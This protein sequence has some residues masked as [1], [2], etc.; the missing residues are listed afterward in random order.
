MS[1]LHRF[2]SRLRTERGSAWKHQVDRWLGIP[3]LGVCSVWRKFGRTAK[4]DAPQEIG[5]LCLG[6]IGDMLL[7]TCVFTTLHARWPHARITLFTS[8][9]NVRAA[10]LVPFV[11]ENKTFEVTDIV[12]LLRQVRSAHFDLFVDTGQWARLGALVCALSGAGQTVGFQTPGQC[13][14]LAFERT[15]AHR[16]DQHELKNFQA[17][18]QAA[19]GCSGAESPLLCAPEPALHGAIAA[20]AKGHPLVA[21][22]P[23]PSG[24]H[25]HLKE[26]PE[27]NWIA[28]AEN[29]TAR[30]FRVLF[31]GSPTDAERI[32]PLLDRLSIAAREQTLCIA[33]MFSFRDEV[34]L[35]Q[36]LDAFISVN[37]GT[38]HLSAML[39]T[40]TVDMHG[41][42][43]P[44]RWG[45]LGAKVIHMQPLSGH[46]A[47]LHLG[48]EY[49]PNAENVLRHLP[50]ASV[51]DALRQFGGPFVGPCGDLPNSTA[52]CTEENP[53]R[54][55]A[56]EIKTLNLCRVIS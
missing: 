19:A 33:G 30:G 22:H 49:P 28:L 43:N 45:G 5:V 38:M 8:R 42:T 47:Y 1:D 24:I 12:G 2:T 44:L 32:A 20:F 17:L 34:A 54:Q 40:P 29:L 35:L 26:W 14:H 3:L 15:A 50:L 56:L 16:N 46:C 36:K 39:G 9:A 52:D 25:A 23:F 48:F 11:N 51:L 4:K 6:A 55:E 21:F 37:T 13:R 10:F 27:E 31:T 18:A 7:A 41:P 53:L